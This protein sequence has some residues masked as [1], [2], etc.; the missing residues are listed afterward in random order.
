VWRNE[1]C[2]R[3]NRKAANSLGFLE[4]S[5]EPEKKIKSDLP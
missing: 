2:S 4:K 1:Q 5:G 3:K